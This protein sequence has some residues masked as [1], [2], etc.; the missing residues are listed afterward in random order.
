MIFGMFS[1]FYCKYCS[2]ENPVGMYLCL[3]H[4]LSVHCYAGDA[5]AWRVDRPT[6]RA[7]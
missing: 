6:S 1:G 3:C 4:G 7:A 2:C 5:L